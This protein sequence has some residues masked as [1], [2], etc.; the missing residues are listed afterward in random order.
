MI[1][2]LVKKKTLYK[3]HPYVEPNTCKSEIKVWS[4]YTETEK[5]VIFTSTLCDTKIKHL[6]FKMPLRKN[7]SRMKKIIL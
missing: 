6:N 4:K 3:I 1:V 5:K 7:N 2:I